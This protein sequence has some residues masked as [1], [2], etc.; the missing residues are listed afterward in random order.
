[1]ARWRW[2]TMADPVHGI[3]QFD[4]KDPVHRLLLDTVNCAAY[5][6]LRRV[7]QMG[8]AEFVF[9]GAT[10][11]RF[12]H[13]LGATYLMT[14][15]IAYFKQERDSR[16]LMQTTFA[17]TGLSFECL[18]L[19]GILLHDVGHPPLSHTLEDVLELGTNGLSHDHHWTYKILTEDEEISRLWN[20]LGVGNLSAALQHFLG[21]AP[22]D[23]TGSSQKHWLASLVSSQ[24][25]MDR[26]DYLQRDSHFLGVKY[27]AIEADRIIRSLELC[28]RKGATEP[29]VAVAEE[30][31]PAIEHYLFGRHQAY[32]MALHSLDKASEALLKLTLQR[33]QWV[34]QQGLEAG[35]AA[36]ELYTLMETPHALST[37]EYLRMDDCYLWEVIHCWS[38][39]AEDETLKALA[40][41]LMRHDLLKFVDLYRFPAP[42]DEAMQAVVREELKTHYHHRGLSFTF[43]F[44]TTTVSPKP[45]YYPATAREP[46]WVSTRHR[47]VMELSDI[48]PLAQT[49][50]PDK[51]HKHLWFVWD[52]EASQFLKDRFYHHLGL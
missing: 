36:K 48:S 25:D 42:I 32:K 8:M 22:E 39:Y 50:A 51:G 20:S 38:R 14:Q 37:D 43:G 11:S 40:S 9:P 46:I 17:D 5:Q 35:H 33:F 30:A 29:V 52:K 26:L 27:G 45:L 7:K 44:D 21:D 31:L 28:P 49:V 47:G 4:R 19:M 23:A 12:N 24:L 1:M 13:S 2:L 10:H 6:R 3:I 18:L 34:R 41:R 16:D 15:A